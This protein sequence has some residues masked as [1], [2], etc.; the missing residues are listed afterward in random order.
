[1]KRLYAVVVATI[2]LAAP[3]AAEG[4]PP[5]DLH[6]VGDHWTAWN[7][8]TSFPEGAELYT[9]EKG[10]TLWDL[11]ER[12]YNDPYLWPQLWERNQYIRDAHW[13]YPGDPLLISVEIRSVET[14]AELEGEGEAV[15]AE[16]EE[17]GSP[18]L[19]AD[20]AAG[21]PIALGSESDIYCSGYIAGPDREFPYQIVGSEYGAVLPDMFG[22]TKEGYRRD[23]QRR[24]GAV[25]T[26]KYGLDT[27]D[28]VYLDAGRSSGLTPG[29]LFTVTAPDKIV[30][31][32]LSERKL[33]R[34][35]TYEGRVRILSVQEET[36]IGEIVFACDPIRVGGVLEPFE[37]EPVP[38]GRDT[39]LWPVNLPADAETLQKAPAIV[40][41]KDDI[42]S[43]G[44][45]H[46]VYIDR[47]AQDDLLP[48]DRFTV[49]RPNRKGLPPVVLG[50]IAVLSVHEETSVAKILKS[51]YAIF[52]GDR[53]VEK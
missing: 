6:L 18:F 12:F 52:L 44:Q 40:H 25:D 8:P 4:P 3:L 51:R 49:Y 30:R 50:E 1:M 9:V 11:A 46:V 16:P 13:I 26:A 41:S 39:P 14:L 22:P 33:G 19:S 42:V 34:L 28:I 31:H 7:P 27:G 20:E 17:E 32:P 2:L 43:L 48:G 5:R 23:R 21:P 15:T 37:P 36:A 47:G 53:L 38:L 24:Y 10:D 35:Y 29:E 45:D